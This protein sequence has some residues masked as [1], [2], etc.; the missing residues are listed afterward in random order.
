MNKIT[1]ALLAVG[2]VF[3]ISASYDGCKQDKKENNGFN[4]AAFKKYADSV[5]VNTIGPADSM[6]IAKEFK[7]D[8]VAYKDTKR[9]YWIVNSKRNTRWSELNRYL[10]MDTGR[11][12]A[13]ATGIG[14][15]SAWY[16]LQFLRFSKIVHPAKTEIFT[17]LRDTAFKKYKDTLLLNCNNNVLLNYVYYHESEYI[18]KRHA[19]MHQQKNN[20]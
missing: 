8:T 14:I 17:Y 4:L 11:A 5:V 6:A 16:F 19:Q 10:L 2:S 12:R 20:H 3:L 18:R 15:D 7:G 13:Y 1:L 9:T